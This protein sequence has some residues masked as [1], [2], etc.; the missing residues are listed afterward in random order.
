MHLVVSLH[1]DLV[2]IFLDGMVN[3]SDDLVVANP[4]VGMEDKVVD[5]L[6]LNG[7]VEGNFHIPNRLG[8]IGSLY[9]LG[10]PVAGDDAGEFPAGTAN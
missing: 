8:I 5:S 7:Y 3:D 2:A 1:F 10:F 6:F 9:V 4:A